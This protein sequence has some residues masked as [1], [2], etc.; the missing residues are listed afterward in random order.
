MA[1]TQA[2]LKAIADRVIAMVEMMDRGEVTAAQLRD[3]AY[4]TPSGRLPSTLAWIDLAEIVHKSPQNIPKEAATLAKNPRYREGT[5]M[6]PA[7]WSNCLWKPS[8]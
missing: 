6:K 5:G 4:A 8:P 7:K 1:I 3:R 2:E